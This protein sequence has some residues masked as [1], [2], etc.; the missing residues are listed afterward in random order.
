MRWA[1][2]WSSGPGG[3]NLLASD[4]STLAAVGSL[5][6]SPGSLSKSLPLISMAVKSLKCFFLLVGLF[7]LHCYLNYHVL[8]SNPTSWSY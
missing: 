2:T 8:S 1:S 3:D 5:L 4:G 6:S 7:W